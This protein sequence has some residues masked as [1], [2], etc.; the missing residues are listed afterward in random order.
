MNGTA[1]S[2]EKSPPALRGPI[3]ESIQKQAKQMSSPVLN[4]F[5]IAARRGFTTQILQALKEG[6]AAKAGVADKVPSS[7]TV[8]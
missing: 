8:Y 7:T 2:G 6:G 1:S 4:D 3:T 5:L